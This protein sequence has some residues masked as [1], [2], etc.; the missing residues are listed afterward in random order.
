MAT[1]IIRMVRF[2]GR[3]ARMLTVVGLVAV[4]AA[5]LYQHSRGNII[6]G[7]YR[8][9]L[10]QL[11]EDYGRLHA[12][13]NEVVKKTA[14]TELVVAGG[15]LSVVIRTAEGIRRTIPTALD[16]RREVHVEY[17]ARR[18]RLWIRRIYTMSDVD[19]TGA[20]RAEVVSI[21]PTLDDL[22]WSKDA[23]LQGLAVFRKE[24]S[25]GRWVVTTT[26]N[27]ALALTR[28]RPGEDSQLAGPP[29]VRDYPQ[30]EQEIRREI[31]RL[32]LADV[33]EGIFRGN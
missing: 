7:I 3:T 25:D 6:A 5:A 15:R 31:D 12:L 18:G 28:L 17:I 21:D 30:L 11:S 4:A 23:D 13:Y 9:R 19:E 22:P 32:S 1:R 29:P 20:A 8:R 24:L 2:A 14:V 10:Q 33:A 16:P 26:G 27:A